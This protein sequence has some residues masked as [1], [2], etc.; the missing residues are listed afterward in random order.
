MA[1][2][3]PKL[4]KQQV[5]LGRFVDIGTEIFAIS[6]TCARAQAMHERGEQSAEILKIADYFCR[7]A[8]LRIDRHFDGIGHNTDKLGYRLAQDLLQ[9]PVDCLENG[10]V[11]K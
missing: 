1:K 5:L 7:S 2:F 10:I 9:T 6:A 3:G 8:R 4:E 11:K